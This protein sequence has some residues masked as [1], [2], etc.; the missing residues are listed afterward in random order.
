MLFLFFVCVVINPPHPRPTGRG[1]LIHKKP[2][3]NSSEIGEQSPSLS[4]VSDMKLVRHNKIIQNE[5]FIYQRASVFS[6]SFI[7]TNS[8][9]GDFLRRK[10]Q[11]FL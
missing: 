2:S 8:L 6:A 9:S 4:Q 1:E 11:R 3:G 5:S 7:A 10:Q